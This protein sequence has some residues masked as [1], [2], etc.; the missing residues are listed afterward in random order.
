[1]SDQQPNRPEPET[2]HVPV[3]ANGAVPRMP[4]DPVAVLMRELTLTRTE[5]EE[6]NM[7]LASIQVQLILAGLLIVLA[8]T[9]AVKIAKSSAD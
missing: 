7:R 8:A 3:D 4:D 1:M 9:L 5:L 6:V 2:T